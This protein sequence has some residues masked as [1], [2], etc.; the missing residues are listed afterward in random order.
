MNRRTLFK[1]SLIYIL[2]LWT[3]SYAN[4]EKEHE[5]AVNLIITFKIKKEKLTSFMQIVKELKVNLPKVK[6][7][8]GVKIFQAEDDK[9]TITFVET[10]VSIEAHKKHIEYVVSSGSWEKIA[11]HLESDPSSNYYHEL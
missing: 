10:W 2:L 1:Q 8:K 9:N 5:M 11:S 4:E 6:G 7:C 3:P